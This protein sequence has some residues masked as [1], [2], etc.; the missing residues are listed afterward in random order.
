MYI[1]R[2]QIMIFKII[3][4]KFY[5]LAPPP[6]LSEYIFLFLVKEYDHNIFNIKKR[7]R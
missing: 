2:M 5:L 4:E 3:T 6:L 7:M 1:K